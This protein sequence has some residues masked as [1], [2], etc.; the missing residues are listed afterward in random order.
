MLVV[1]F[2]LFETSHLPSLAAALIVV[3]AYVQILSLFARV[4][5]NWP[6][7]FKQ[8]LDFLSILRANFFPVHPECTVPQYSYGSS[9]IVKLV[10]LPIALYIMCL[11]FA[12]LP[13]RFGKYKKLNAEEFL[14]LEN[15]DKHKSHEISISTSPDD[16]GKTH[17]SSSTSPEDY[18]GESHEISISTSTEH[19]DGNNNQHKESTASTGNSSLQD[20]HSRLFPR[21]ESSDGR[22]SDTTDSETEPLTRQY[23]INH[24]EPSIDGDSGS[25]GDIQAMMGRRTSKKQP[26]K[27]IE[28]IKETLITATRGY[29][30]IISCFF[31]F[32]LET[33][34]SVLECESEN[35][36]YFL[37]QAPE[38]LC[39]RPHWF[40]LFV[41]CAAS[42]LFY[43]LI[44]T[45]GNVVLFKYLRSKQPDYLSIL[46]LN[47][48]HFRKGCE[49]WES[50]LKLR[51]ATLIFSIVVLPEPRF[52]IIICGF[53]YLIALVLQFYYWPF[54]SRAS[55][56]SEMTFILAFLVFI[57]SALGI[58]YAN[59]KG[60]SDAT[61]I[62]SAILALI[63]S[64]V[65]IV[66]EIKSLFG[67]PHLEKH[68]DENHH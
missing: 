49:T 8:G 6:S 35:H 44:F 38:V 63:A 46:E 21:E 61:M 20:S 48:I 41:L 15:I 52:K 68:H 28:T 64:A 55:N 62:G 33:S 29:I 3:L 26:S 27:I 54:H 37:E 17:E 51:D 5:N 25:E 11:L 9:L 53:I 59:P 24:L 60:F 13:V 23:T 7:W 4:Q 34:S 18:H 47:T 32:L 43:F 67:K 10:I 45:I 2:I 36:T 58:S 42:A 56:W 30:G 40:L 66:I 50:V 22:D 57:S 19:R 1:L 14:K 39:Y 65:R 16:H 12:L 31:V